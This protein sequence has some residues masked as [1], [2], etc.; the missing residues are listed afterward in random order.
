MKVDNNSE[1]INRGRNGMSS[2]EEHSGTAGPAMNGHTDPGKSDPTPRVHILDFLIVLANYRR[3]IVMTVVGV[4]ALFVAYIMVMPN[5]FTA[6]AMLLP[7]EKS[8]GMSM[9]GALSTA[10]SNLDLKALSQNS[11]AEIFAAIIT[12]RSMADSLIRRS[13]LLRRLKLDSAKR[14][15]A[16][17]EVIENFEIET[18]KNGLIKM[19]YSVKTGFLPND[20]EQKEASELSAKILNGSIEV[21]DRINQQKSV[22]RARR[23]R[24][25]LGRRKDLK[26]QELDS[27]QRELQSFQQRHKAISLDKQLDAA[28]T[29]LVETEMQIQKL[30]LELLRA[31]NDLSPDSR[32]VQGLRTQLATL[33]E[34]GRRL[35]TGEAGPDA[36]GI[37]FRDI[38]ELSRQYAN[39]KLEME[40]STKMYS[41]LET[42]YNQ[43]QVQ[44]AREMPTV[45]VLD[46][47]EPPAR[48]SWPRRSMLLLLVF[49]VVTLGTLF[50]IFVYD[51]I[52]R[53]WRN[54][55]TGRSALLLST[56]KGRKGVPESVR[57][58]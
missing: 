9:L 52:R 21:L 40:L 30:E 39:L 49:P 57:E 7:P 54:E 50:I 56:L 13:D 19:E 5:T 44:E 38:P 17:D 41:F 2:R 31:Q 36:L 6:G 16:I 46:S 48:R 55:A 23:S 34:R 28:I 4:M 35:E 18:D 43:E 27:V 15:F 22:T 47:A 24:E 25:F 53:G 42:Q 10:G 12:S 51:A 8:D 45:S 33:R 1:S 11:S 3:T 37:P 29:A 20:A 14:Q 32:V 26:R 58:R